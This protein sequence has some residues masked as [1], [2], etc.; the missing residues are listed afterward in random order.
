M[1]AGHGSFQASIAA[2]NRFPDVICIGFAKLCQQTMNGFGCN[3]RGNVVVLCSESVVG[4]S[5][6]AT[7][8]QEQPI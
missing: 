7:S 2:F 3:T 6:D 1:E 5:S 4:D 8:S